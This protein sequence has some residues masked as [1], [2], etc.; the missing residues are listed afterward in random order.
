MMTVTIHLPDRSDLGGGERNANEALAAPLYSNGTRSGDEARQILGMTRRAFE[1]MLLRYGFS[2]LVDSTESSE[3]ENATR[4]YPHSSR[5]I[6]CDTGPLM[7]EGFRS[8][9]NTLGL[10][11]T[12]DEWA[13]V[14]RRVSPRRLDAGEAL[15]REGE[16]GREVAYVD[17]GAFVYSTLREGTKTVIGFD[18]EGDI[19][20]D[21]HS[22]FRAAP[23]SKSVVALEDSDVLKLTHEDYNALAEHNDAFVQLRSTVMER[24][25]DGAQAR[26]NEMQAYSAEQRYRRLLQRS[27][28]VLQRVPL[29]MVASY[30]GITPEALSRVR[31]RIAR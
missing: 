22:F 6:A 23:A 10:S 16:V 24:L 8:T 21:V 17:Q 20:G 31:R 13:T 12:D 29:Y 5:Q 25:F 9:L 7:F 11:L 2:I 26:V 18:F 4:E 27:P 14:V 15:V 28:H 30:I 3:R 1:E 19:T